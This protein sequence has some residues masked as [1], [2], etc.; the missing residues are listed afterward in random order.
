MLRPCHLLL[1]DER[2][3]HAVTTGDATRADDGRFILP[4][5]PII[6]LLRR[7]S[8]FSDAEMLLPLAFCV[9][10]LTNS[11]PDALSAIKAGFT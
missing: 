9:T 5:T 1:G 4:F 3:P 7:L 6:D 2:Q 11:Q 8:T 10:R